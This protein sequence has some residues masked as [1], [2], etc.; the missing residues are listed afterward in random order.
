MT[1]DGKLLEFK[2]SSHNKKRTFS[3]SA[4][5]SQY[6]VWAKTT[7]QFIGPGTYNEI[8]PFL[9]LK[10]TPCSALYVT[11]FRFKPPMIEIAK[12]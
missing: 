3:S 10:A 12:P 5:F 2:P 8:K 4:R 11:I 6:N 9:K 7:G 1:T